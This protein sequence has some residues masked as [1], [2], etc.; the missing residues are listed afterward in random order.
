MCVKNVIIKTNKIPM[1]ILKQKLLV[2][3]L[4]FYLFLGNAGLVK[5][6]T[7][8]PEPALFYFSVNKASYFNPDFL[9]VDVV[10]SASTTEYNLMDFNIK[11]DNTALHLASTSVSNNF[12]LILNENIN[13]EENYY[14]LTGGSPL[15][16]NNKI[17]IVRLV[18]E[19][20]TIGFTKLSFNYANAF[21]ADGTGQRAE[22]RTEG[23]N[24]FLV[25]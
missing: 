19:K 22:T 24:V 15:P 7:V 4:L 18:F 3:L 14:T 11:F 2:F 25:K 6:E 13:N 20:L 16:L 23:H 8:L 12:P 21:L 5:A 17:Q 10:L 9:Y 1:L